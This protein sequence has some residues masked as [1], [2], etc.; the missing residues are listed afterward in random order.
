MDTIKVALDMVVV[1]ALAL[2]WVL[3]LVDL[4]IKPEAKKEN[5]HDDT[6]RS[7]SD[8]LA[9]LSPTLKF[10]YDEKLSAVAAVLLFA[11]AYVMGAGILRLGGDFLNDD[12]FGVFQRVKRVLPTKDKIHYYVYCGASQGWLVDA[13][14]CV[15][16]EDGKRCPFGD[17]FDA[18]GNNDWDVLLVQ[19][20]R[21]FEYQEATLL[22]EGDKVPDRMS[23]IYQQ[24]IVLRGAVLDGIVL[25]MLLLLCVVQKK[26]KKRGVMIACGILMVW[27]LAALWSHLSEFGLWHY[28]YTR[29][30]SGVDFWG[31]LVRP[32]ALELCFMVMVALSGKALLKNG[33]PR[34]KFGV[35][36][37]V[38]FAMTLLAYFGWWWTEIV[39]DELVLNLY[40]ASSQGLLK[41]A[42]H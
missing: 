40:V 20:R 1:G 24:L 19:A 22:D 35:G 26:W 39:Y 23:H 30:T 38:S 4:Y 34:H 41:P 16:K 18:K 17:S 7:K 10:I 37:I 13:C 8:E 27:A 9:R 36:F 42:S 33:T 21:V 11:V 29:D 15:K 25:S 6:G 5:G 3:L 2:P 32:P 28:L 12:D 14:P 31:Y